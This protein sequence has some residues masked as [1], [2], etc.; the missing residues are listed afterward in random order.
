M[1]APPACLRTAAPPGSA[2]G[3][4]AHAP[5]ALPPLLQGDWL[6]LPPAALPLWPSVPLEPYAAPKPVLSYLLCPHHLRAHGELF[7]RVRWW[8][9][10]CANHPLGRGEE[11]GGGRAL[12]CVA[13]HLEPLPAVH[14]PGRA[15]RGG[16]V[17]AVRAR[18][19][20]ARQRKRVLHIRG[21][22]SSRGSG[23]RDR[24]STRRAE[25]RP[26][27]RP[28]RRGGSGAPH[29]RPRVSRRVRAAAAPPAGLTATAAA[30]AGQPG[31]GARHGSS[32]VR[33]V[34]LRPSGR[35]GR[36]AGSRSGPG[37]VHGTGGGCGTQAPPPSLHTPPPHAPPP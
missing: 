8:G 1:H 10:Q 25:G 7:L 35:G 34:P 14:P 26:T 12:A 18:Q 21:S 5:P 16:H 17:R 9:S 19:P 6:E 23:S 24:G 13:H 30:G 11:S 20:R 15:G 28:A 33:G 2:R 3:P 37:A 29:A 36:S 27:G 4:T 31:S 22:S 32:G